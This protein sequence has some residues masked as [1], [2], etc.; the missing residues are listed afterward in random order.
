LAA[1]L[2]RGKT[3]RGRDTVE[4][5]IAGICRDTWARRVISWDDR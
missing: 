4:A 5:E 3:R 1:T 2:A